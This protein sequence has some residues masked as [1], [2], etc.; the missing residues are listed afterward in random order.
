M[1]QITL[2][3]SG[4][5]LSTDI[6]GSHESIC[7]KQM[8]DGDTMSDVANSMMVLFLLGILAKRPIRKDL[9]RVL[10]ICVR[11]MEGNTDDGAR[12]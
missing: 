4:D 7:K 11:K 9:V 6:K 5:F 10:K 1:I 3:D 12:K 8:R 2:D